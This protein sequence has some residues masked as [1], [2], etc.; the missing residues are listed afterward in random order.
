MEHIQNKYHQSEREIQKEEQILRKAIKS[1]GAFAP[2]YKKYYLS[3]FKFV[4]QRVEN[5]HIASEIVS[6]VFAKAIFNLKKYKFKTKPFK[7]HCTRIVLPSPFN[8][9]F[10][11]IPSSWAP[12]ASLSYT[13]PTFDTLL[14]P[15][16]LPLAPFWAPLAPSGVHLCSPF[17]SSLGSLLVPTGSF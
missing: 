12:R 15:F 8:P 5:E 11:R 17:G 9:H 14:A 10:T 13:V 2:I 4:L 16:W 7:H 6:D 1:P 3:I